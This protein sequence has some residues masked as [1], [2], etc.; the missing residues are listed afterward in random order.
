MK[1]TDIT[2]TR[3]IPASPG[4]VFDVWLDPKSPGGPWFGS[5]RVILNPAV[6][7]LF[8][9]A[10]LHEGRTWPITAVSFKSIALIA[11]STPGCPKRPKASSPS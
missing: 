10:V 8:Y 4:D 6:D 9:S 7:G 3:T 5:H 2:V 1:L 11:W